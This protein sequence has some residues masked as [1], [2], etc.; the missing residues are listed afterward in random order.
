MCFFKNYWLFYCSRFIDT[1]FFDNVGEEEETEVYPMRILS[2]DGT[3]TEEIGEVP[4]E[5]FDRRS[6]PTD[7][8]PRDWLPKDCPNCRIIG[9]D[10]ESFVSRWM[11]V[12]PLE[13]EE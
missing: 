7:C 9:V 3:L 4:L 5:V 13:T 10:F 8:W 11:T 6:E 12:C 1:F 2:E